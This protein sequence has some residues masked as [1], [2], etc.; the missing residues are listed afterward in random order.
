MNYKVKDII[1]KAINGDLGT[2]NEIA[3]ALGVH[4]QSV[5]R[6]IRDNAW[7]GELTKPV[8]SDIIA[9]RLHVKLDEQFETKESITKSK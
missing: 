2:K 1:V 4:E 6:H 7:N 8:V 9:E 3:K 5:R